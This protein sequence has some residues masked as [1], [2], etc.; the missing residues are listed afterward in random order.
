[1]LILLLELVLPR[2]ELV[3]IGPQAS[4][5]SHRAENAEHRPCEPEHSMDF[6]HDLLLPILPAGHPARRASAEKTDG[7]RFIANGGAGQ[8]W[9]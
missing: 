6:G 4:A 3:W 2:L 9:G 7:A 8:G 5:G 1:V